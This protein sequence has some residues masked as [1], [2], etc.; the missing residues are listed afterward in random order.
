MKVYNIEMK[1][2]TYSQANEIAAGLFNICGG[3][4]V[5][6]TL[7]DGYRDC[8]YRYTLQFETQRAKTK[9]EVAMIT[10]VARGIAYKT[11]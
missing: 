6:R 10:G 3:V 9:A 5:T 2:V 7:A 11:R 8:D 4:K 1:P